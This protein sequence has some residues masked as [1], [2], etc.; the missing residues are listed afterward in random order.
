MLQLI[1]LAAAALAL[2]SFQTPVLARDSAPSQAP[3]ASA[4]PQEGAVRPALWKVSDE[5]TT[6][7][8]F[9]T[10]HALPANVGWYRGPVAIA[11]ESSDELVTEIPET[12][13][14]QMA[15]IVQAKAF[16]PR[17]VT[18]RSRLSDDERARFEG[19]LTSLGLPVGALDSF[20]P[21]YAAITLAS[22]P[23]LRAGYLPENGVE[24]LLA[25]KARELGHPRAG[26]ETAEYQLGLFDS[27]PPDV[28]ERYAMQIV[29]NLPTLGEELSKIIDAW[30]SGDADHLAAMMNEQEDDPAIREALLYRRNRAWAGWIGA[31]LARPGE[32]FVAVGAGHLAGPG[33]VQDELARHGLTT[34]R[35]Q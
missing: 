5:D 20:E 10:V 8:L 15:S 28:Q 30:K 4:K 24:S 19:A 23:I 13:P 14:A 2:V 31:R 34:I 26:L 21:W 1:R 11:F 27:L 9:G 33:S 3:Q 35:V 25:V 12:D 7:W 29:D 17:G 6:I 18:L 32:V 22:M 16:L